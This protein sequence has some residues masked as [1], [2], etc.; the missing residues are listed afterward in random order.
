MRVSNSFR[1]TPR[2]W[3]L[4]LLSVFLP[5]ALQGKAV[6]MFNEIQGSA[7][8][9]KATPVV[10]LSQ[11][12]FAAQPGQYKFVAPSVIVK[13]PVTNA[14]ITNRFQINYF[15]DGQGLQPDGTTGKTDKDGKQITEDPVTGTTITR[16]YGSVKI[17]DKAGSVRI[18]VTATPVAA[19]A[20]QYNAG[21]AYYIIAVPKVSPTVSVSP[22][23]HMGV[24][25][26]QT[27]AAPAFV[28]TYTDAEGQVH[29]TDPANAI[30]SYT[31]DGNSHIAYDA[32]NKTITGVSAGTATIHYTIA[33][34]T[35]YA[36][37]FDAVTQD[38]TVAVEQVNGKI[39][40]HMV[41]LHAEETV[42]RTQNAAE[43]NQ[44]VPVVYDA[45][46][47]DVT[48]QFTLLYKGGQSAEKVSYT[49][50]RPLERD[51]KYWLDWFANDE[52]AKATNYYNPQRSYQLNGI[53]GDII[54][55][56]SAT[57]NNGLYANPADASYTLHVLRRALQVEVT[58]SPSETRIPAGYSYVFTDLFKVRGKFTDKDTKEVTYVDYG[59]MDYF[60]AFPEEESGKVELTL[61][62]F[63]HE[64]LKTRYTDDEGK[65]WIIFKTTEGYG[66][67]KVW[68]IKY[69]QEGSFN[70]HIFIVPWNHVSWDISEDIP[71]TFD[72]TKTIPATLTATPAEQTVYVGDQPVQ[73]VVTATNSI[74]GDVT[75]HYNL[76]YTVSDPDG[77]G[78]QVDAQTGAITKGIRPGKV[79]V[80]VT[81]TG[82]VP[83]DGYETCSTT[84]VINVVDATGRFAYEIVKTASP[85]DKDMGKM[86]ITGAGTVP[87]GYG[88]NGVPGL[89]MMFGTNGEDGWRAYE[90]NGRL[91]VAD[92]PVS[93]KDADGFPTKG[94]YFTLRPITNG[95][96]TIDANV[97]ANNKVVLVGKTAGGT[98]Y[99]ENFM[100]AT[101][102][103]GEHTFEH[104][105]LAGGTY[106]LY[107]EGD[108]AGNEGLRLHGLNFLPA[109]IYQRN[110]ITPIEKATVFMNGYVGT[111]LKL[112]AER[113][114]TISYSITSNGHA[115]VQAESGVVTPVSIGSEIVTAT[116]NSATVAGVYRTPA[117]TVTVGAIPTYVMADGQQLSVGDRLTTTNIPT[118]M[119][120]TVGGWKDGVGPYTKLSHND[121][122]TVKS[123]ESLIDSWK[124]SKEDLV[125]YPLDGF[126]YQTQGTQNATD[127]DVVGY[128]TDAD[129]T[130]T[131]VNLP[132]RGAYLRFEP[133][134]SGT[135]MVYVLQNGACDYD[136]DETAG[137]SSSLALKYRPLFITDETGR[138]EDL[139]NNW[140]AVGGLAED[141]GN[142]NVSHRGRYTEGYY[143]C[144]MND[145]AIAGL[146]GQTGDLAFVW[147]SKF[148]NTA[149]RAALTA[150]WKGKNAGT[151]EEVIRLS[152]GGYTLVSKA[153]VR[154]ALHVKAGKSY[155]VFQNGS[156]L[157][158]CGF[159][160][161]PTNY[162]YDA[163][164]TTGIYTTNPGHVT[165]NDGVAAYA[166]PAAD[167]EN[168]NVTL[169]GRSL[170]ANTWAPICLPFAVSDTKFRETF[171][172]D[173]RIITFNNIDKSDAEN[174]VI[175]F[176]QHVYHMIVAGQPYFIRPTKDISELKFEHVSL[177]SDVTAPT[178]GMSSEGITFRGTFAKGTVPNYSYYLS[179]AGLLKRLVKDGGASIKGFRSYLS[180]ELGSPIHA[181]AM[182]WRDVDG[183][184]SGSLTDE[185][186]GIEDVI[187]SSA[188]PASAVGI[189]NLQ[190]QR[191]AGHDRPLGSLPK[192]IYIVDGR[193]VI[194]K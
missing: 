189:Y 42:Y 131:F 51:T 157:G 72:V 67:D 75:P 25:V 47:N 83:T 63:P 107:N 50:V 78:T 71:I 112:T 92:G 126:R 82:K 94:T 139:D 166:A 155:Y 15:V 88:I 187:G 177:E 44:Q 158:F 116:V 146:T 85:S 161:I 104:P 17:G 160:F 194:V 40:T 171:G 117:Y 156:K 159:A 41:F 56:S 147:D 162:V 90:D 168:V 149:D 93:N 68:K 45:Y 150:G 62:G 167:R 121:D 1:V 59:N 9:S 176:D 99:T 81:A 6:N 185:A 46:G 54:M 10:T 170:T 86:R 145:A 122:G 24:A 39:A 191:V 5:I 87:G 119:F 178:E 182:V 100:P 175:N 192:G 77:T 61:D 53:P 110:D 133:E 58:P 164:N 115:T 52:Y 12:A 19:Y 27:V 120:M 37:T 136:E 22:K 30:T 57:A 3:R 20:G 165:L 48:S 138:N 33:P 153:Y 152:N 60:V 64:E 183:D 137:A 127:E 130:H 14:D 2:T 4:L 184:D 84:Y 101:A 32:A 180:N 124:T 105:L 181:R 123:V 70:A 21:N 134:E 172:D 108:G 26:G 28:L 114:S 109:F 97:A 143:R 66:T 125:G 113:Q 36:A 140:T 73:P 34:K 55:V 80:T 148:S 79:T 98:L 65:R 102:V 8:L 16:L 91:V 38:V 129:A 142:P 186:T 35:E 106:C 154:Y 7:Q 173:A 18:A 135:L 49:Y 179:T 11:T 69:L 111:L 128:A 31:I 190:G 144:R 74:L 13:D 23:P 163:G 118:R 188:A 95:F 76:T 96:L 103:S 43:L 141:A 132:C 169:A 174:M 193:K 151:T 89:K 29:V